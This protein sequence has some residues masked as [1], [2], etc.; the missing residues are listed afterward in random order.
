V[1][2][3]SVSSRYA[4]GARRR[5]TRDITDVEPTLDELLRSSFDRLGVG[6]GVI[7][8]ASGGALTNAHVGARGG[9]VEVVTFDGVTHRARVVGSDAVGSPFG[10]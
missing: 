3:D 9:E 7:V 1:R 4:H 10:L 8:D 6:S 5:S 2:R